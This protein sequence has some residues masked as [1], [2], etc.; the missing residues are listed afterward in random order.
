MAF[1]SS[2]LLSPLP[3]VDS[4][5]ATSSRTN[6]LTTGIGAEK[7][8]P[9]LAQGRVR[10][11]RSE[12]PAASAVVSFSVSLVGA[13]SP[14]GFRRVSRRVV[15]FDEVDGYPPSAGAEGD[16]IALGLGVIGHGRAQSGDLEVEERVGGPEAHARGAHGIIAAAAQVARGARG[17]GLRLADLLVQDQAHLEAARAQGERSRGQEQKTHSE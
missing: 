5:A 2:S 10:V 12:P 9:T 1:R 15:L 14:R 17:K 11:V 8:S 6:G 4:G 13:N 7:P 3:D 16:Q